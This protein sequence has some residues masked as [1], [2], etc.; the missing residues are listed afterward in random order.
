MT[1]FFAY[2]WTHS[3]MHGGTGDAAP[4]P[5]VAGVVE[6]LN[7]GVT[8]GVVSTVEET[9]Q[10]RCG[11]SRMT[12]GGDSGKHG[13][14]AGGDERPGRVGARGASRVPRGEPRAA[15]ENDVADA[16]K[17]AGRRAFIRGSY[18]RELGE[19]R[20]DFLGDG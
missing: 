8:T 3:G 16:K 10:A 15:E 9:V 19:P 11:P 7:G 2:G 20:L 12:F 14:G 18:T 6:A 5:G 1:D 13:G 17:W 4:G